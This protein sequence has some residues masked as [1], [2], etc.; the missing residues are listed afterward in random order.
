MTTIEKLIYLLIE[1][2]KGNYS[3]RDFSDL[4]VLYYRDYEE[5]LLFSSAEKWLYDLDELCG[6]FSEYPEDLAIPNAFVDEKTIKAYVK[7]VP[8]EIFL[9]NE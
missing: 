1:Y 9:Y 7:D 8:E 5:A 2:N 4:F 6:R 3:T